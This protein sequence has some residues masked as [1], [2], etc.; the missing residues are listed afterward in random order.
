MAAEGS[1]Q[2]GVVEV[3]NKVYYL[4]PELGEMKT[5]EV[6]IDGSTYTFDESGAATGSTVP[7]V[8]KEFVS[9]GE[10]ESEATT[11][12]PTPTPPT[13]ETS[14]SNTDSSSSPAS[15]SSSS[16]SDDE[17]SSYRVTKGLNSRVSVLEAGSA[18][19]EGANQ[20]IL[21]SGA[22]INVVSGSAI[23]VSGSAISITIE[24]YDDTMS[25]QFI[26]NEVKGT[27]MSDKAVAAYSEERK[28]YAI[29][30]G[31]TEISNAIETITVFARKNGKIVAY[32]V[33]E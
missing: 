30:G 5:G 2:T 1:M 18:V 24:G 4:D 20:V 26:T 7:E 29:N 23:V 17:S 14:S 33:A 31:E 15:S 9:T 8:E 10:V 28:A 3:D 32:G 12:T 6:E 21:V 13:S 16:S 19:P 22:A 27:V 25:Y 11:P